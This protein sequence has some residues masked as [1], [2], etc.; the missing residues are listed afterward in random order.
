MTPAQW[1]TPI[2][3]Y[4]LFG[5]FR[6]ASR[7]QGRWREAERAYA[8]SNSRSTTS[9]TTSPLVENFAAQRVNPLRRSAAP[10]VRG[11][12]MRS[13]RQRQGTGIARRQAEREGG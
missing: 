8:Y 2:G 7:G 9:L 3:G 4:R 13:H 6:L 11:K 5:R 1:S 12:T 10:V